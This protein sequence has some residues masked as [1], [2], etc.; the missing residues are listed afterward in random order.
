MRVITPTPED[1][2]ATAAAEMTGLASPSRGSVELSTWK[3]AIPAAT[4]G[5]EHVID[6]EQI[7]MVT[8]GSI[9]VTADGRTERV[10]RGQTLV[11][12]A[13][14]VRAVKTTDEP[15]K[16]FVAMAADG[17]VLIE[18]ERRPVPWAR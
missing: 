6:R 4:A 11:L 16:A 14:A 7:W 2:T 9:E 10:D 8:A 13:G 1:V 12:P 18:G 3:V 15:A 5:P 17:G